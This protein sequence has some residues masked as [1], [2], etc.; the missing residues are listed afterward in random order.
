MPDEGWGAFVAPPPAQRPQGEV[1]S[2]AA[3]NSPSRGTLRK[4]TFAKWR[5][6][7]L[8]LPR[9]PLVGGV[10]PN[11]CARPA[12]KGARERAREG[13]TG[14]LILK[15]RVRGPPTRQTQLRIRL[16]NGIAF[17]SPPRRSKSRSKSRSN[18]LPQIPTQPE[19]VVHRIASLPPSLRKSGRK[20]LRNLKLFTTTFPLGR[21]F[22]SARTERGGF[23]FSAQCASASDPTRRG[24]VSVRCGLRPHRHRLKRRCHR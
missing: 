20:G 24:G 5:G 14:F 12:F 6:S 3:V 19:S 11:G 21:R 15:N 17:F 23:G 8:F 4:R 1:P 9:L 7:A 18:H 13:A 10:R 22:Q 2:R 16:K